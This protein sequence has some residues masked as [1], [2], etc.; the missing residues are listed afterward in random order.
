[1]IKDYQYQSD[2]EHNIKNYIVIDDDIVKGHNSKF[3]KTENW[4]GFMPNDYSI[5]LEH[6]IWTKIITRKSIVNKYKW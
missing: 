2:N 1:M 5:I 3:F 4:N 6:L